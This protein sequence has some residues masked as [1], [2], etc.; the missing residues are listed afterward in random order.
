MPPATNTRAGQPKA[1]AI[2]ARVSSRALPKRSAAAVRMRL[3][4]TITHDTTTVST[5]VP[6]IAI[7]CQFSRRNGRL[8]RRGEISLSSLRSLNALVSGSLATTPSAS[9]R[10]CIAS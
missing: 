10:F 9:A 8:R 6:A 4:H 2:D 3:A 5:S 7:H 1:K